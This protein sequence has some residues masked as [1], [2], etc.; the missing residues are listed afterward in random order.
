MYSIEPLVLHFLQLYIF[1][2]LCIQT[3]VTVYD[4]MGSRQ[5]Q[6]HNVSH[7]RVY[8]EQYTT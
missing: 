6:A 3:S 8:S 7:V 1:S 2:G 4:P 5:A